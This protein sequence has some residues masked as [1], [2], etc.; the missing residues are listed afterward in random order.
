[1]TNEATAI[2]RYP[3][4]D[5]WSGVVKASLFSLIFLALGG[6]SFAVDNGR[7]PINTP[8][9]ARRMIEDLTKTY[10]DRYQGGKEF[11][12]TLTESE[13]ALKKDENDSE[14]QKALQELIRKSMVVKKK[15]RPSRAPRAVNERRLENKARR[16]RT[17]ELR[18]KK[19]DY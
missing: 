10:G 4:A 2:H 1:M 17:K 11:L 16:S 3:G 14:A 15:R 5:I 8:A 6:P 9:S 18:G 12:A 19:I 7:V 13:A